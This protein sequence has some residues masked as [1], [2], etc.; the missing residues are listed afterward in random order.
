[1]NIPV[2]NH[3]FWPPAVP[4]SFRRST[5]SI[6]RFFWGG[7]DVRFRVPYAVT[8]GGSQIKHPLS[9]IVITSPNISWDFLGCKKCT[10]IWKLFKENVRM[11]RKDTVTKWI[12]DEENYASPRWKHLIKKRRHQSSSWWFQPIIRQN[13][14]LQQIGVKIVK[15]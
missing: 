13:G 11:H 8:F 9:R 14:N 12:S 1:M 2:R 7:I 6:W 10:Q 5:C 15:I 3:H 4:L